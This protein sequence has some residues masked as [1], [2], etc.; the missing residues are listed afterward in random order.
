MIWLTWRQYRSQT[1][2]VFG[3]LVVLAIVL[4]ATGPNLVHI[5]NTGAAACRANRAPSVICPN[6]V[7]NE[8]RNLQLTLATLALLVPALIGI[9]WGA[10]LIARE[11]E[12]GSYKLSW[13]QSVTRTRWLAGKLTV[14]GLASVALAGLLSLAATWWYSP[15]ETANA[16]RFG[17]AV[18]GLLGIVP[19]G[20]VA[21]AF[22]LGVT[23]GVLIGRTLPAMATTLA[24]FVAA[25]LAVTYWVRPYLMPPAHTKLAVSATNGDL[26]IFITPKGIFPS[27]DPVSIPNAWVYSSYL[28]DKASHALT[29]QWFHTACP[30]LSALAAHLPTAG[31]SSVQSVHVGKPD[32]AV[33]R[34]CQA[35]LAASVHAVAGQP[36]L[37]V[38][39]IGDGRVPRPRRPAGRDLLLV[40]P[41]PALVIGKGVPR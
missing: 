25:R 5:Y 37:G 17:T 27:I 22:V 3:L 2:V 26:G 21:F 4:A 41:P 38:P 19:I 1:A 10:P 40:A 36:L 12:T 23:A 34:A 30:A 32:A 16:D 15:I 8:D 11:L 7:V 24:A 35:K 13:T 9:F 14:V 20:Y 39:G 33:F 18:F 6:P 28:A 31:F 29:S